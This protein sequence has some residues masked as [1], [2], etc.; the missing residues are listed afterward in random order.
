MGEI[1][2]LTVIKSTFDS[3]IVN[4]CICNRGH[5]RLLDG[6]NTTFWMKNKDR[7]VGLI[8]KTINGGTTVAGS[9]IQPLHSIYVEP[10]LTFQYPH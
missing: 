5:L 3:E 1:T 7:N 2:Y 4:V 9:Y 6:R 10:E 8:S